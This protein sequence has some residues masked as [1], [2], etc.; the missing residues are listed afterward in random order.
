MDGFDDERRAIAVL[1]IGR[2]D[3]GAD[4]QSRGVGDDMAFAALDLLAGVIAARSA[5]LGGLDRLAVDDPGRRTWLT[6]H[7]LARREQQGEVDALPNTAVAPPVKVMLH[8]RIR[9]KV[10]GQLAPLATRPGHVKQPV[11]NRP[12][13]GLARSPE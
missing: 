1:D 5:T 2:V 6:A 7:R 4:E 8:G 11:D 9:G 13:V 12:K 3:F 10:M